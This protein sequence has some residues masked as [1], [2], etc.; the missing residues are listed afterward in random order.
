MGDDPRKTPGGGWSGRPGRDHFGHREPVG[1]M[2][3]VTG[4]GP[5]SGTLIPPLEVCM[6]AGGA[7]FSQRRCWVPLCVMGSRWRPGYCV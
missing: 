5:L 6:Q 7:G 4:A 3:S 2:P 1:T